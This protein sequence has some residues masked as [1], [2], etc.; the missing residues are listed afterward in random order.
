MPGFKLTEGFIDL[1]VNNRGIN[2]SMKKVA[3]VLGWVDKKIKKVIKRLTQLSIALGTV[4]LKAFANF[5]TAMRRATSVSEAT[6]QQFQRM[7]EMAIVQ[8][9]RLNIS[10]TKAA[11]AFYFLGSAG[12]EITQQMNAYIPVATLARAATIEM[13]QAAEI[14]VDT[15]KG[16]GIAFTES[17][18]VTDVLSKAV[19]SSNMNYEQLGQT[20]SMVSGVAALTN[21]TLE[22]TA[23]VIATMANVGIKGTRAGTSLR[24]ALLNLAAPLSS[25]RQELEK[26]DVAVFDANGKMKPFIQ[27]VGELSDKLKDAS[28]E[29]RNMAF[30]VIFGARAIAGQI[31]IFN[32]GAD[33][34]NQFTKELEN[35]GGTAQRI[36]DKQMKSFGNQIGIIWQKIKN[37]TRIIGEALA[38]GMERLAKVT[39]KMIDMLKEWGNKHLF[40]I[41]EWGEKSAAAINFVRKTMLDIIMFAITDWPTA[42]RFAFDSV[43]LMAIALQTKIAISFKNMWNMIVFDTTNALID[44][45]EVISK[46]TIKLRPTEKGREKARANV[47]KGLAEARENALIKALGGAVIG[48]S[49]VKLFKDAAK[50]IADSVPEKLAEEFRINL[51]MLRLEIEKIEDKY[52]RLK[53]EALLGIIEKQAGAIPTT[54]GGAGGAGGAGGRRFQGA[55]GFVGLQEGFKQLAAITSGGSIQKQILKETVQARHDRLKEDRKREASRKKERARLIRQG[56]FYDT[57][58]DALK[59]TPLEGT[60]RFT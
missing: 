22:E 50:K 20:L 26:W 40:T 53:F 34:L 52:Q 1:T 21:N 28:E 59:G 30:R 19:I 29:E 18:R 35:S 17:E 13:G 42:W 46:F 7:S 16:F 5:E 56:N 41:Q 9:E 32:R 24:R 31:A 4:S 43:E 37:L 10:A 12:L 44:I 45:K 48:V 54:G 58:E 6:E 49:V 60:G 57:I 33:S 47:A 2:K 25:I 55:G 14:L 11:D 39:G 23:A 15:M 3:A 38:P 51:N 36:A 27:L 8:S